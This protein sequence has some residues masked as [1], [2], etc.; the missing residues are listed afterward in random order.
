[1]LLGTL[2]TSVTSFYFGAK[3]AG[4]AS[5]QGAA[6]AGTPPAVKP[7]LRTLTTDPTPPPVRV[8][9]GAL[10][11]ELQLNGGGLNNVKTIKLASG[12]DQFTFTSKSNDTEASCDVSCTP[13]VAVG[14]DWDVTV[15]DGSGTESAPLRGVLKF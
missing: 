3:T 11:F 15:I 14:A 2:A 13:S 8:A 10:A 1:M 5:A 7:T 9:G 12:N 6:Q 4:S